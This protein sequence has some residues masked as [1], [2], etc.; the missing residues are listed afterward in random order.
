MFNDIALI[1]SFNF[2]KNLDIAIFLNIIYSYK[3]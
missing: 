3:V 1:S 2:I